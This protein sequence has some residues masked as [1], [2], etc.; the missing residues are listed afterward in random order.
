MEV[1]ACWCPVSLLMRLVRTFGRTLLSSYLPPAW[2]CSLLAA[3]RSIGT[4]HLIPISALEQ[5]AGGG[6]WVRIDRGG[7]EEEWWW[8][9]WG[10]AGVAC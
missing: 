8:W 4:G 5:Q 7:L 9:G 2:S 1:S 3:A 6:W 10:R